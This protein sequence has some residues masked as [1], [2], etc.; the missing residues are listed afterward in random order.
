[1]FVLRKPALA[2]LALVA[3]LALSSG[4]AAA[5]E[6]IVI[7]VPTSLG[8]I[9]GKESLNT[10]KLA[11]EEINKAGG[12]K[13]GGQ[14]RPF[15]VVSSDIRDAA[16]GVP[17]PEALLGIEKMILED[18]PTAIVV[19]PFRSEA[20]MAAMDIF[21][22][23]KMP[24]L[25]TIAMTPATEAKYKQD[26]AKYKYIF[27]ISSNAIYF[28][29]LLGGGMQQMRE[30]FGFDKVYIMNQDVLWA[31][32]TAG[33]LEKNYF[34]KTGWKVLGHDNFPTGATDFSSSLRKAALT[35]AQVILVVFDMPESGILIKQWKAQRV[36]AVV[37][38]FISPMAGPGAWDAFDHNIGGLLNA[39]VE[40]G[41]IPSQHYP[42]A[43]KFYRD[44][45][46]KYGEPIQS[47]HGPA[48]AY[49]AVYMLKS[50]IEHANSTDPDAVVA[51]L[52][53]VQRKGVVGHLQINDVNQVVYGKDPDKTGV[54][55][56]FQWSEDGK[57][58]V[59][60]P[61][62]LAEGP[63]ELPPWMKR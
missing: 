17:V 53:Q 21:A 23:Y 47:G 16:A 26:P 37:A 34:D 9:E 54:G 18:K 7:G 5:A 12:V 48:P 33:A 63:I 39:M 3:L 1:M 15:K 31:R 59:T 41:N 11:V 45:E 60:Y 36:P 10:V 46:A 51:A 6:P 56:F 19:G 30:K 43:A 29:Q 14:Q 35:G 13:V 58:R 55:V 42:M 50:A 28:S 20:L 49:D 22:K 32:G 25:G 27:R 44:Y 38:G 62:S 4:F 24:M 8:T 57:R 61:P 40:L 52:K 2:T